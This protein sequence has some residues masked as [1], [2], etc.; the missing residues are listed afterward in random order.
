MVLSRC[1]FRISS[2]RN[3]GPAFNKDKYLEQMFGD[4]FP[5]RTNAAMLLMQIA[6]TLSRTCTKLTVVRCF[7]C[8]G[9]K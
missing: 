2:T 4:V 3:H 9:M 6:T 8:Q 5:A 7:S 1:G